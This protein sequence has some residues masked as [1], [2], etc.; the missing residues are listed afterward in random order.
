M[1]THSGLRVSASDPAGLQLIYDTNESPEMLGQGLLQALAASRVLNLDEA[2]QF[3]ESSSMKQRYE[4]WV[5]RLL[6]HV[7]SGDRIKLFEKMKHCSVVCESDLISIRPTIHDEI[8]G[9]SGSKQLESVQVSRLASAAEVGQG[10]LLALS[11]SQ[12]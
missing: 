5:T 9:W 7:G 6:Q 2:R 12:G 11:R 10:I 4:N 1:Q 8:E 3:F